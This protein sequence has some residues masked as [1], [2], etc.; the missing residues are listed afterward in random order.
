MLTSWPIHIRPLSDESLHSWLF[1]VAKAHG[2]TVQS[3][4]N[5]ACDV[6]SQKRDCDLSLPFDQLKELSKLSGVGIECLYNSSLNHVLA[7][8]EP[9]P[10]GRRSKWLVSR[11]GGGSNKTLPT[12]PICPLCI[13]NDSSPYLRKFWRL[14]FYTVCQEHRTLLVDR[15]QVCGR[16]INVHEDIFFRGRDFSHT[17]KCVNCEASFCNIQPERASPLDFSVHCYQ[18]AVGNGSKSIDYRAAQAYFQCLHVLSDLIGG[19]FYNPDF[20]KVVSP[21]CG[22]IQH[23]LSNMKL[24]HK[25]VIH[26]RSVEERHAVMLVCEFILA[27]VPWELLKMH[28]QEMPKSPKKISNF[29]NAI[30]LWLGDGARLLF[31][32]TLKDSPAFD[33]GMIVRD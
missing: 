16:H 19:E 3:L 11:K 6:P 33:V 14:A 31:G 12:T 22:D 23:T 10:P 24:K 1:R 32:R 15:C 30:S 29:T 5:T 7:S 27:K 8:I 18:A 17:S 20:V 25:A 13:K 26:S 2:H 4:I 21:Y 28:S 9:K